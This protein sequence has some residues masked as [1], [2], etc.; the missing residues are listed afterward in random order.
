VREVSPTKGQG[1]HSRILC[2]SRNAM[3][4]LENESREV[5]ER[6]IAITLIKEKFNSPLKIEILEKWEK[7]VFH[8]LDNSYQNLKM[9]EYVWLDTTNEEGQELFYVDI[10]LGYLTWTSYHLILQLYHEQG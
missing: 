8:G 7:N 6:Q 9:I 1:E 5:V 2:Q 10:F 3:K 4:F